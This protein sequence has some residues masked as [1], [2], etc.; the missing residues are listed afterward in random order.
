MVDI[1]SIETSGGRIG[2]PTG[3]L[4][5]IVFQFLKLITYVTINFTDDCLFSGLLI[6][7]EK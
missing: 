4:F 5:E 3:I 6:S 2:Y 1:F 7:S